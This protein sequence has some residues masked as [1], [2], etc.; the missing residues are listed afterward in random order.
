MRWDE[1]VE[2]L[3]TPRWR[4]VP[5]R[6][7]AIIDCL[8]TVVVMFV[9]VALVPTRDNTS[10][11]AYKRSDRLSRVLARRSASTRSWKRNNS[12]AARED[13]RESMKMVSRKR[14]SAW[15]RVS[16]LPPTIF[17]L[18]AISRAL[19][20]LKRIIAGASSR[21]C[22]R[23]PRSNAVGSFTRDKNGTH[24]N[25]VRPGNQ[26]TFSRWV[27]IRVAASTHYG[28]VKPREREREREEA[29]GYFGF[30]RSFLMKVSFVLHRMT[31]ERFYYLR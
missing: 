8:F 15:R 31:P 7:R 20:S 13:Q 21:G 29:R 14:S 24:G 26:R 2:V 5:W 17:R 25:I 11:L 3:V 12:F 27:Y 16:P 1:R 23:S 6:E 10:A 30:L 9:F 22:V 4:G 28:I 19:S 18:L